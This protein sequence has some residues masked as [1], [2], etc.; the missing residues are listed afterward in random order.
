MIYKLDIDHWSVKLFMGALI[1]QKWCSRFLLF[2]H[3]IKHCIVIGESKKKNV[4]LETSDEKKEHTQCAPMR[5]NCTIYNRVLSNSAS[6]AS[7]RITC[8]YYIFIFLFQL[9]FIW[10]YKLVLIVNFNLAQDSTSTCIIICLFKNN[11]MQPNFNC[12]LKKKPA[13]FNK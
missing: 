3:Q 13:L 7:I 8:I 1:S 6:W 4:R 10:N 2:R 12:E 9:I 5:N 11:T